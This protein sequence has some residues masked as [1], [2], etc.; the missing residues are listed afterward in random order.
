MS[1]WGRAETALQ[2]LR[3]DPRGLGGIVVT[4]RAG[5]V[6][7]A[8][9]AL[10]PSVS[11]L[12]PAMPQEVLTGGIDVAASL[13]GGTLVQTRGLLSQTRPMLLP[14]AE[15]TAPLMAG[16]L[17]RALDAG[18]CPVIIALDEHS[19][20]EDPPPETLT[21]RLALHVSLDGLSLRDLPAAGAFE[22]TPAPLPALA[23]SDHL[24]DL[25]RVAVALGITSLRAPLY[26]LHAARAYAALCGRAVVADADI[27]LAV[28]LVLAPRAT[29]IPEEAPPEDQHPP[30]QDPSDRETDPSSGQFLPDEILL[31]AIKTALP[32]DLL[33]NG[34]AAARTATG[35]GSGAKRTG[36]RRGRPLPAREGGPRGGQRRVDI[37]ATLRAAVPWQKLR[38]Q[39]GATAPQIYPNDLR[40]KRYEDHSDRVLIFAV[41]A[42]GSAAL[43]R[44][45]EA[46]GAVELLLAEAYARRDHV[47]LI[48]FR[49]DGAETLLPPTRSLVQTKRRLAELP[50]G[51]GTPLAS[52]LLAGLETALTARR[53]GMD[54]VIIVLTDGRS[55]VT[56]SG[57]AN[58][59]DAAEDAN[60]IARQ[61]A[62]EGVETIVIDSSRRPEPQLRSLAN[63]MRG[64][65]ASLPRA[66]AAAVSRTVNAQL[67]T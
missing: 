64:R 31:E 53:K 18:S 67:R 36:N 1:P 66:D 41:D 20:G 59:E 9:L 17:A 14:M 45:A 43:A 42:S 33:N 2:L 50:G 32:P 60:R 16:T 40:Y 57:T 10:L 62:A 6:R 63:A 28:E 12:H 37:P 13:A 56:L 58:R 3:I 39:K 7:E 19:T 65:Y 44:L 55:N 26:A 61:I 11:R 48:A 51:G 47:S 22:T 49:G 5:P 35:S 54:P 27:T 52:G 34:G 38:R 46:K 30:Q 8:L 21:D 23:T 15:R 24:A 4:A 29:R 25:T